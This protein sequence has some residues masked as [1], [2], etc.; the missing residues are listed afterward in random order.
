MFAKH[1]I[2]KGRSSNLHTS[3]MKHNN[4]ALLIK[5]D[6]ILDP[7]EKAVKIKEMLKIVD[8]FLLDTEETLVAQ[9]M[10]QELLKRQYELNKI[11]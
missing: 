11:L 5:L 10:K 8:Y 3:A 9:W 1:L 6:A 4:F 7:L 2:V